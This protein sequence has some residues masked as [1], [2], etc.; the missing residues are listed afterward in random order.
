MKMHRLAAFASMLV[1]AGFARAAD[2]PVTMEYRKALTGPGYVLMFNTTVK[3]DFPAL[4][5]V[6]SAALGTQRRYEIFLS[7]RHKNQFGPLEGV[8]VFP[9]D[10]VT[11]EN[12]NYS[13]VSFHISQ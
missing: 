2:L 12:N 8:K 4:M 13:S 10:D 11:L 9:G 7:W 1:I 5:T 3:E 6:T